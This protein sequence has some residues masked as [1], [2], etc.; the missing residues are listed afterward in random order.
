MRLILSVLLAVGL[1]TFVTQNNI[2]FANCPP[3]STCQEGV[4]NPPHHHDKVIHKI[5]PAS[6]KQISRDCEHFDACG[7]PKFNPGIQKS[8]CP[9]NSCATPG[10]DDGSSGSH[11]SKTHHHSNTQ[12]TALS[13]STLAFLHANDVPLAFF[14]GVNA[15]L[16]RDCVNA[17]NGLY[18]NVTSPAAVKM[19]IAN[20]EECRDVGNYTIDSVGAAGLNVLKAMAN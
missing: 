12:P 13:D 2:A 15:T 20:P 4:P 1:L 3:N 7:D 18:H 19:T 16:Y 6:D 5:A 9:G 17:M 8:A 11:H 14:V 10:L